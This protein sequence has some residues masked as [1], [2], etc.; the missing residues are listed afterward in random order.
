MQTNCYKKIK[1]FFNK[2]FFGKHT[3]APK[4]YEEHEIEGGGFTSLP[5]YLISKYKKEEQ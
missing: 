1:L 4:N 2:L 5:T 3:L